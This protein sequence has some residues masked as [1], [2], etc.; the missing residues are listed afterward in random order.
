MI[1][2]EFGAKTGVT[3]NINTRFSWKRYLLPQKSRSRQRRCSAKERMQRPAQVFSCEYCEFLRAPILKII[4]ERLV[5]KIRTSVR[6]LP[7]GGISWILSSF[8]WSF[9]YLSLS[10]KHIFIIKRFISS[11]MLSFLHRW[12]YLWKCEFDTDVKIE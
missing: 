10:L 6:N 4:C 11:E 2:Q 1:S 9:Q 8:N 5:L 3:I 12:D 7:K